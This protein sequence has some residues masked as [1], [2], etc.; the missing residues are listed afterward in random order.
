MTS[1]LEPALRLRAGAILGA[2]V[3]LLAACG[4]SN[5]SPLAGGSDAP[6]GATPGA[7]VDTG[8]PDPAS[9]VAVQLT[10]PWR[11]T[12][13]YLA[14]SQTATISDACA[15]KA[16][17]TLGDVEANLPTA[18]IDARGEGFATAILADGTDAIDCLARVDDAGTVTVDA[19][20]RLSATSFDA[21]DGAKIDVTEVARLDDR[22][23]G[24]TIA[25]GR[26]G[27][28]AYQSK[29]S[30]DD[31]S[32]MVAAQGNGWWAAWWPGVPR[33]SGISAVDRKMLVIGSAKAPQAVLENR[34]GPAS[35]W[36]DP[37]ASAPA[38]DA[39]VIHT[40]VLEEA[41]ASGKSGLDPPRPTGRRPHRHD[42]DGHAGD[43]PARGTA[44]LPGQ[45]AVPVRPGAPGAARSASAARRR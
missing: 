39:T 19:V 33:A 2:F 30:F 43:P 14:D 3:V 10:G 40:R 38:A 44:G 23:G 41:C 8:P 27:P 34:T 42:R 32:V 28:D 11:R 16:R 37:T 25:F 31:A 1:R 9:V 5:P 22:T 35:W 45:R 20:D 17:E 18:V 15:A 12:P 4:S 13:I 21:Q 29:L 7:S 36:V 6:D 26:V 24:R